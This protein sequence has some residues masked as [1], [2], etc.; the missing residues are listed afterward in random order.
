MDLVLNLTIYFGHET[1]FLKSS[2]NF[3]PVLK[4][5][6]V[7]LKIP[8]RSEKQLKN[9]TQTLYFRARGWICSEEKMSTNFSS[10]K[11]SARGCKMPLNERQQANLADQETLDYP[12]R[13]RW[14]EGWVYGQMSGYIAIKMPIQF[15]YFSCVDKY[16]IEKLRFKIINDFFM[17]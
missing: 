5:Y 15:L 9:T 1:F 4:R 17:V 10:A 16:D 12:S 7:N 13:C 11:R 6:V 3:L 8:F 2:K 14:M